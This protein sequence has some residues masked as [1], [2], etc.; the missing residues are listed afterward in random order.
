M[1]LHTRCPWLAPFGG[2]PKGRCPKCLS[3]A[4]ITEYHGDGVVV[5]MCKETRDDAVQL[6]ADPADVPDE[7]TEHLCRGCD[8]CGYC[9]SERV[10]GPDDLARIKDATAHDE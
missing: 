3:E 5:G 1:K 7:L 9:W 6:A 8:I 4:V 2:E 10:A